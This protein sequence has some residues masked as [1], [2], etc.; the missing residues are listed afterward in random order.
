MTRAKAFFL[1]VSILTILSSCKNTTD[2]ETMQP[3]SSGN[4]I[5]EVQ[6]RNTNNTTISSNTLL[7][8]IRISDS[9]LR[10][11]GSMIYIN[12]CSGDPKNLTYW[13]SKE[14]FPSMGIA[15]FI[16]YP[17]NYNRPLGDSFS[18]MLIFY[19]QNGI[20]LPAWIKKVNYKCPWTTKTAFYKDFNSHRMKYLRNLL[21]TTMHLQAKFIAAR[22]Q[23]KT[24]RI[25]TIAQTSQTKQHVQYQFYRVA[26]SP[27][28]AYA[29]I[30]YVNFKGA[31]TMNS[32]GWGLLQVLEAMKGQ[33]TGRK[34][35]IEFANSAK[36]VL[37]N[38]VDQSK[39]KSADEKNLRGWCKRIDTYC[40]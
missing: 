18:K 7:S 19:E 25:F 24:N 27:M 22:F 40:Q 31:G 30:D 4:D 14:P 12:E 3:Y 9:E 6:K 21:N 28:G 17:V 37:K 33:G 15:H 23:E 26:N 13:N 36:T 1:A 5:V 35:V 29:L 39:N 34:A 38:R 10:A 32:G 16:W 11:I 2:S 8:N 20:R